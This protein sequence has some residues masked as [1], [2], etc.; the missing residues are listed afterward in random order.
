MRKLFLVLLIPF[1]VTSAFAS[2]DT[3]TST[4]LPS[5]ANSFSIRGDASADFSSLVQTYGENSRVLGCYDIEI[6][7]TTGGSYDL[8]NCGIPFTLKNISGSELSASQFYNSPNDLS[9]FNTVPPFK[10]VV[11]TFT[12]YD[13]DHDS[14]TDNVYHCSQT[15]NIVKFDPTATYQLRLTGAGNNQ[16]QISAK[17]AHYSPVF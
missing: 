7:M 5:P 3:P 1:G 13:H 12:L 10:N 2:N 16:C 4:P 8:Q 6:N 9:D 15:L 17:N 11:F 14:D